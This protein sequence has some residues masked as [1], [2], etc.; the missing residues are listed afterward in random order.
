MKSL[1]T[2]W[3]RRKVD[4]TLPIPEIMEFPFVGVGGRYYSPDAKNEI[5]TITGKP[6]S[7]RYGVIVIGDKHEDDVK[8]GIIAHEWRHHMQHY[9]GIKYD[10]PQCNAYE[11]KGDKYNEIAKKYFLTSWSEMDALRFQYKHVGFIGKYESWEKLFYDF[12]KDLHV[13]PIITYGNNT[14]S[15][16]KPKIQSCNSIIGYSYSFNKKTR[17]IQRG[18][19]SAI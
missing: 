7:M 5:Y 19:P 11:A 1:E 3:I 17:R 8:A 6:L 10:K 14:L 18:I 2:N 15:S 9:C 12:V 13:K 4:K 16:N